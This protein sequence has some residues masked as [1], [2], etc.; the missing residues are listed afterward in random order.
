MI[1]MMYPTAMSASTVLNTAACAHRTNRLITQLMTIAKDTRYS[2]DELPLVPRLLW[3]YV[4][5]W[6]NPP[7]G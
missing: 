1:A 3:V 6:V 2:F 4:V 7:A 5:G